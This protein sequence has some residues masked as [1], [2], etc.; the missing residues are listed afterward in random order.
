MSGVAR[1]LAG[2]PAARPNPPRAWLLQRRPV[3]A[4][5][6]VPWDTLRGLSGPIGAVREEAL[7]PA[8]GEFRPHDIVRLQSDDGEEH[9]WFVRSDGRVAT[10]E[11][12]LY[13]DW[14]C[15]WRNASH[16]RTLLISAQE[17]GVARR[18][19]VSLGTHMI[20]DPGG[21]A[22]GA[23]AAGAE[24]ALA[25]FDGPGAPEEA[26][27]RAALRVPGVEWPDETGDADEVRRAAVMTLFRFVQE[28]GQIG[29][30]ARLAARASAERVVG[31]GAP[32][33]DLTRAVRARALREAN[34]RQEAI[35]REAIPLAA[36][37]EAATE[38]EGA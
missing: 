33:T 13:W 9:H 36:L 17:A 29:E 18:L 6:D 27:V 24:A 12:D 35:V 5:G 38:G 15:P 26:A 7:L 3:D 25:L 22:P 31:F 34:A 37:L 1:F 11:R 21:P 32:N 28:G 10:T 2:R 16:G 14:V 20:R 19:L 23:G 8:P 30:V 4:T